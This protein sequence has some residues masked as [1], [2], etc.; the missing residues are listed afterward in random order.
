M[1]PILSAVFFLSALLLS[2]QSLDFINGIS[3]GDGEGEDDESRKIA[4]FANGDLLVAG[5]FEGLIDFDPNPQRRFLQIS[6][7]SGGEEYLAR[8]SPQGE[9]IW[10]KAIRSERDIEIFGL[11]IDGQDDVY[12]GHLHPRGAF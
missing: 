6:L 4:F 8:Y 11:L 2:A 3:L 1:R 12:I 5:Q 7:E 10:W 9:L